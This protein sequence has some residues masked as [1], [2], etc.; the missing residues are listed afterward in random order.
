MG[1]G[2]LWAAPTLG[3]PMSEFLNNLSGRIARRYWSQAATRAA[4]TS[5]SP[6]KV[7][8]IA[9]EAGRLRQDLDAIE[10]AAAARLNFAAA[11]DNGI[12]QPVSS[13]W[14][15]RPE[16]WTAPLRPA[17]LIGPES[18]TALG[19]H[20]KLFHDGNA[21]QA[22]VRQSRNTRAGLASY[23]F[24]IET[25]RFDASYVSLVL[26]L[27]EAP[28]TGLKL[29]H[30]I[31]LNLNYMTEGGLVGFARL[32]VKHGPNVE[33]ILR[34]LPPGDYDTSV[35]FDMAYTKLN[36]KRVEAMWLD[37][38]FE[39]PTLNRIVINDLTMARFPRAEM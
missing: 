7:K 27:P 8:Q 37:L 33:T 22:L 16:L 12:E 25:F 30:L 13:D 32:N 31:A 34:E 6:A 9:D 23:R 28:V 1:Q 2:G 14:A 20:M 21:G 24:E 18:G 11:P 15:W 17:V 19:Q 36:E 3:P 10:R 5:T 39:K 4:D 38:I 35:E 26:T 29:R